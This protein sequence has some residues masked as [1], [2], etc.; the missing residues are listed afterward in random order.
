MMQRS[1][2]LQKKE[3]EREEE[4]YKW[5]EEST[6]WLQERHLVFFR[7]SI[8]SPREKHQQKDER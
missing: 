1:V 7:F 5:V 3:A 6:K 2:V 8:D 4:E